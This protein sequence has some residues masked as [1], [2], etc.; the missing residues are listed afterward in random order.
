MT[1]AMNK[2]LAAV[3]V[4][5]SLPCAALA[6]L[7]PQAS[8]QSPRVSGY[9]TPTDTLNIALPKEANLN[10]AWPSLSLELDGIDVTALATLENGQLQ[11]TPAQ[12][13]A[14]GEHSLRL[15]Q[16]KQDGSV[17][18]WG[19]W[20]FD[21]R[22]SAAIRQASAQSQVDVSLNQNVAN[23]SSPVS[24]IPVDNF[25]AQGSGQF[26][27][28]VE[29]GDATDGW[30]LDGN[31]NLALAD[32]A[33][34]SLTGR[35]VDIP[36]FTVTA[37]Q[38][39]YSVTAGDQ[40]LL[41]AGLLSSGY[42][43][44]GVSST[45]ALGALD[46]AVTVFSVAANHR[47]GIDGGLGI[48]DGDNRLTG[49][50][51]QY[52]PWQTQNAD[53][54][55]AASYISGKSSQADFGSVDYY[56]QPSVNEGSAWNLVFDSQFM[57]QQLRV[58]LEGANTEYDFDGINNGYEAV[59]DD[60]WS[61]LVLFQP[62]PP[63]SKVDLTLGVEAQRIGSYYYSLANGQLP[64]DKKFQR[65]FLNGATDSTKGSWYWESAYTTES[66]NLSKNA[67]FA[68]TDMSQWA[69]SGGY[70]QYE[71][72]TA[73]AWLGLPS[74]NIAMRGVRLTDDYTPIGYIANNLTTE[75][76]NAS[77]AFAHP[78]WNWSLGVNEDKLHD[79]SGW[80][81]NTRTRALQANAAKQF[82]DKYYLAIG[83]QLQQ[84]RFITEQVNTRR[85]LYSLDANA[86]FIPQVLSANISVGVNQTRA[87]DDPY[88]ALRDQ[89]TYASANIMWQVKQAKNNSAGLNLSFSVSH[90]EYKDQLYAFNNSEGY[91]AFIK[92][93]TSLPS[94]FPGVL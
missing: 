66:N 18:E 32:D 4:A 25:S 57:Q 42:Q 63:Q 34:Q 50:R 55:L 72:A 67:A 74:Y 82:G 76:I 81:P 35:Q 1:S 47:I 68:I 59:K 43:A 78:T 8:L 7:A 91:Q 92:L 77:A 61:A 10:A 3:I 29:G 16:Y 71:P 48:S 31:A 49:A 20:Q 27:A 6:Q 46:S 79:Y 89:S 65:V 30:A 87:M 58:R 85:Q 62:A 51:W 33:S 13:L 17:N 9:Y 60:A 28:S 75:S 93:S 23:H 21:V 54:Y 14:Y 36:T 90:N 12:R 64:A 73:L 44:R 94:A 26:Y 5:S 70:N 86:D 15:V 24:P 39:R 38:G 45:V 52:Q 56:A 53:V 19:Y 37:K 22:Q 80:Q 69:L 84:T 2:L 40:A 11:Y 88:Y 83:W 41:Q